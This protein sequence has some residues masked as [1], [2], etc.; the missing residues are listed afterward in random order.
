M[1]CPVHILTCRA[2]ALAMP[3][4]GKARQ[5]S[6]RPGAP[7]GRAPL[8]ALQQGR[9]RDA[10]CRRKR[11][12]RAEQLPSAGCVAQQLLLRHNK[13][14][15]AGLESGVRVS[16]ITYGRGPRQAQQLPMWQR[17][18]VSSRLESSR[19]E[20][21]PG[22]N[23]G[24]GIFEAGI[25][26]RGSSKLCVVHERESSRLESTRGDLSGWNPEEEGIF[27]AGNRRGVDLS[28]WNPAEEG[29]FKTFKTVW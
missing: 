2:G 8:L 6:G 28:G 10:G 29:I 25:H 17:Q 26:E 13:G 18:R 20:D 5:R 23:P 4:P 16:K 7:S 15:L 22:W 19:E 24:E 11:A 3:C 12:E 9:L 27:Q 14:L 1:P 21:P